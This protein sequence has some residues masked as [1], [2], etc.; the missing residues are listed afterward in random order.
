METFIVTKV[1]RLSFLYNT[2][3]QKQKKKNILPIKIKTDISIENKIQHL[4]VTTT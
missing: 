3:F 4:P 1:Q 2:G